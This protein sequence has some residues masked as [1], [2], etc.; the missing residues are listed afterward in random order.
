MPLTKNGAAR[1]TMT[2]S[3]QSNG[4]SIKASQIQ[5]KSLFSAHHTVVMLLSSAQLLLQ[6]YSAVQ[7]MSAVQ[8][9]LSLFSKA[10][11]HIGLLSFPL[12]SEELAPPTPSKISSNPALPSP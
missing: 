12:Y 3:M 1:C 7:S 9:T 4:L 5:R 6:I 8:A 2:S 11:H 10:L